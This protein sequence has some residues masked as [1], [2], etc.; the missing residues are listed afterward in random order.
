ME[1]AI[2]RGD[3]TWVNFPFNGHLETLGPDPSLF[4]FGL[5][6]THDLDARFG[7]NGT[8]IF[9]QRDVPGFS[10]STLRLLQDSGVRGLTVGVNGASA[11]PDVPPVFRWQHPEDASIDFLSLYNKGGYGDGQVVVLPHLRSALAWQFLSD[12]EGAPTTE[13]VFEKW[14]ELREQFP[15]AE[16]VASPYEPFFEELEAVREDLPIFVDEIGDTWSHGVASDPVKLAQVLFAFLLCTKERH[17]AIELTRS[18][19]GLCSC[20]AFRCVPCLTCEG[21]VWP[22]EI[23]AW[24][25]L[26]CTIS[27]GWR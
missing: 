23:A 19:V 21:N 10:R 16:I 2:R 25:I 24:T 8:H 14:E 1:V 26:G 9:S 7:K 12:N 4:S 13:Q 11:P 17:L 5:K 6:L 22:L 27:R 18:F 3:I 20:L 15:N